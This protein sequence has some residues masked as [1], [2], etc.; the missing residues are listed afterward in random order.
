[1]K[2]NDCRGLLAT[3]V[4]VLVL[5]VP[6]VTAHGDI[7]DHV[8]D[9]SAHLEEYGNEVDWLSD[10][11]DGLVTA[12]ASDGAQ[13]VD[14]TD[15][16]EWWEAVK[17]HGAIEVNEVG[18]YSSIWRALSEVETAIEE[19][20]PLQQ[21]QNRQRALERSLW[22]GLGAVKL[23]ARLQDAGTAPAT[24][25]AVAATPA[26][27]L[28]EIAEALD[29]VVAQ[30][31]QGESAA[32]KE[33]VHATYLERFEGVEG[34]LI[35][36][37]PALVEALERDFNVTLP[38]LL[39]EGAGGDEVAGTVAAMQEK[40]NRARSLLAAAGGNEREVF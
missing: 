30:H 38:V 32:A 20:R 5:G 22:E 2:T 33:L 26:T 1:V 34:V 13:A 16:V 6:K 9:L 3:L 36:Q 40:L 39:D 17:V 19:A 10:K 37:D 8:E 29:A 11:V 31:A 28:E 27:T 14:S 24:A 15:L 12:Y 4:L 18:L 21:L 7:G 25:Q 35:E 23:A